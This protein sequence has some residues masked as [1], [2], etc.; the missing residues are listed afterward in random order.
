ML[1]DISKYFSTQTGL[2]H[3]K[4]LKEMKESPWMIE[5][6]GK[7]HHVDG[8]D[9]M[10]ALH[11]SLHLETSQ[12]NA[13]YIR[14]SLLSEFFPIHDH[15]SSQYLLQINKNWAFHHL[16]EEFEWVTH[17]RQLLDIVVMYL[18]PELIKSISKNKLQHPHLHVLAQIMLT[19]TEHDDQLQKDIPIPCYQGNTSQATE[20]IDMSVVSTVV[21][22][23]EVNGKV[24]IIDQSN[25]WVNPVVQTEIEKI[26]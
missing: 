4:F 18:R 24:Y 7:V 2:P 19:V 22:Q 1:D 26:I 3:S 25:A 20:I 12:C 15:C 13:T 21:G 8:G 17:Y 5:S 6:W 23:I 11:A 9:T 16:N 14:V 10:H